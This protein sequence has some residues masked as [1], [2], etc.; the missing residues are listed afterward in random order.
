MPT[1]DDANLY[2]TNYAPAALDDW[3]ALTDANKQAW[4]NV[5]ARELSAKFDGYV[6][7]DV[8]VYEFSAALSVAFNDTNRFARQGVKSLGVKNTSFTFDSTGGEYDRFITRQVT[9]LINADP[10]NA[11]LPKVSAGR[12]VYTTIIG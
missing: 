6:I 10:A 2:V 11:D 4:L 1:I 8:A 7:P 3:N 12:R 9:R 5:A